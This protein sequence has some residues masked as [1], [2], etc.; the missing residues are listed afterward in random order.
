MQKYCEFQF[1]IM[2]FTL[3]VSR[4]LM[5]GATGTTKLKCRFQLTSNAA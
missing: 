4:Q 3:N 5:I 2:A 1:I